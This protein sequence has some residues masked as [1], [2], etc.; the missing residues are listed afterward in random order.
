M[1]PSAQGPSGPLTA[2]PAP[3]WALE[4]NSQ[5]PGGAPR[6]PAVAE[7]SAPGFSLANGNNPG[8]PSLGLREA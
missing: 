2:C 4:H 1:L 7:A 6:P 3:A 8:T 5:V